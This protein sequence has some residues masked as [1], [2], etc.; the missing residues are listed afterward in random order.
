MHFQIIK[1]ISKTYKKK[2]HYVEFITDG[3]FNEDEII[4]FVISNGKKI[5]EIQIK[6]SD[7]KFSGERTIFFFF[8]LALVGGIIL[9]FALCLACFVLKD[10][11][12]TKISNE[13]K[14][15][16]KKKI[17]YIISGIFFLFFY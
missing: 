2:S 13:N 12:I 5:E 4:S 9:N 8:L 3:N 10:D 15:L 7:F 11:C 17:F 14:F 16:I 6:T 1:Y